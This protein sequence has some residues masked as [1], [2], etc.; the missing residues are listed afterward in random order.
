M[1]PAL[2][3]Y[4]DVELTHVSFG[5]VLGEDGRPYKTRSG[6]TVGLEGLLDEAESRALSIATEQNSAS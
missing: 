1:R 6:E 2:W 4:G 5:T 3:G